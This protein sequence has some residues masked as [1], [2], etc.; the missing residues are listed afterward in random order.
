MIFDWDE[1]KAKINLRK[2]KVSFQEASTVFG[3]PL[4][5][6]FDDPDHSENES[7]FIIIG[8]SII[9][10]LLF[11]SHADDGEKVRIISA[12]ETTKAEREQYEQ[13]FE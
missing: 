7:R 4:S 2:H 1:E 6:T 9:G 3:D 10:R 5:D 12:R 8:H 11:L 13:E